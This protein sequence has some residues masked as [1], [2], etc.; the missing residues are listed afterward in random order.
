MAVVFLIGAVQAF[1]L[2]F[3]LSSNR[4]NHPAA[5]F[6]NIWMS[7]L[8]IMLVGVYLG[9]S[10]FYRAHPQFFGFDSSLIL[11]QGPF[12]YVYV[13]LVLNRVRGVT[14]ILLLHAIP[15][16]FFTGYF[17]YQIH[18][19]ETD[20]L[21]GHIVEFLGN[22]SN[23]LVDL[24][25]LF[26]HL[27]LIVYL[28]LCIR[29][30]RSHHRIVQEEF[31]YTEEVNLKW[32]RNVVTGISIIAGLIV[33]GL[34]LNDILQFTSHDFKAF[35]IYS[36]FSALPF[37][38]AFHAIRQKI[39]YP[40]EHAKEEPR[41]EASGL[42][43][44]ES[45]RLAEELIRF[46]ETQKPYLNSRLTIKELADGLGI[47][48]KRLSQVINENFDENFFNF[49]NRFRVEE[50]QRRV[51]DPRFSHYTILA[52]GLD[53]GFNTKS[54]FNSIF[55]K[56]TGKTPSEFRVSGGQPS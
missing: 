21:F 26:A 20:D 32:L 41:Y 48:P 13:L 16:L 4:S 39:V 18:L 8:G 46:V 10:G 19:L 54:S 37:Y 53:C 34:L 14:P 31:S 27:H 6:L 43:K 29:L 49:I 23:Y 3:V 52:I 5:R 1:F 2:A 28:L 45:K 22:K 25:G 7:F 44:E 12:L 51:T 47:H 50:F 38:L 30:L 15:F 35:M 40:F 9:A 36:A 17:I 11:L 24:F 56:L 42:N 55:K 33:I